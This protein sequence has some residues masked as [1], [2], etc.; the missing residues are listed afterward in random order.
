MAQAGS[1]NEDKEWA[2]TAARAGGVN[3]LFI[4]G[5]FFHPALKINSMPLFLNQRC[6]EMVVNN[7]GH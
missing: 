1:L 3:G 7:T 2:Q 4:A 5:S 6:R